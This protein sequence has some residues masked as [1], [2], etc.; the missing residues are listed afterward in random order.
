MET[1]QGEEQTIEKRVLV[2]NFAA[3]HIGESQF[4][5]TYYPLHQ[6][7][8][9]NSSHSCMPSSIWSPYLDTL[10][11]FARKLKRSS[12]ARAGPKE[13]LD[14]MYKVDSYI[15]ESQRKNPLVDRECRSILC[16]LYANRNS[17]HDASC[18]EG[19]HIRGWHPCSSR[20]YGQ[21]QS[22]TSTSRPGNVRKP[23]TV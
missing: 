15:K 16:M 6:T 11:L 7:D 3:I 1:A 20:N 13:A 10:G 19:L 17:R 22:Y 2:V 4:I 21:C 5:L 12:N 9:G 14:Q 23:R 18:Q 8:W